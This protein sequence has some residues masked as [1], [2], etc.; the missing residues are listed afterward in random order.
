METN[1]IPEGGKELIGYKIEQWVS[2]KYSRFLSKGVIVD[3][4][5]IKD[6]G[7]GRNT[8]TGGTYLIEYDGG[9]K[10]WRRRCEFEVVV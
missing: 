8:I 2:G 5:K 1:N 6:K 4:H 3:Y 7:A 9:K 10:F